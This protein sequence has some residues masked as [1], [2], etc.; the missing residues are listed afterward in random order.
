MIRLAACLFALPLAVL[1]QDAP[2]RIAIAGLAHG[3]VSGFLNA[4]VKRQDA[5]IVA[6]FD[7]DP[8]LVAS[9][10]KRFNLPADAQFTD[11]G[12]MLDTV[13][14]EAVATFTSTF[15]HTMVVEAA[16]KRKVPVMMEKPLAVDMKHAR[17]IQQAAQRGGIPVIVN[18][19]T[20]WY[21]SHG[22]IWKTMKQQKAG[23]DIRRMVAMDGHEGPKEI[24]V[25][26]E[27]FAWLTDPVKNGAGALFDFGCYGANLMTWLM[28]NQ[29]PLKVTALAQTNKPAIYPKVDDES[30]ILVEYPKAQGIIQGSWNW[31][32]SRKDF[33]VYGETGYA[34]ATGGNNLKVR[35]PGQR[36]EARTP[37]DLPPDEGDSISYLKAVAR[38][39]L[40][41]SGLSSLENNLI[42]TEILE[43]ARESIRSGK[44][45]A[46]K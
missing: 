29:R 9:Y 45:I 41:P 39:K 30:T 6:I 22:E 38:G 35:L 23:G 46:L 40:K 3:H 21:K 18:Y 24:K 25:Q 7:L 11:L 42:V 10:A 43:A 36:E 12:K 13:K 15:D 27:F 2:L 19:E 5:K 34:I 33:E 32:F 31:P 8:A 37:G 4:A 1:A 17:A 44:T 16:A 20:T 14:P 28:D 26:P